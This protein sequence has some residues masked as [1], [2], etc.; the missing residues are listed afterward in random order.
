MTA[1][2]TSTDAQQFDAI[3]GWV[4]SLLDPSLESQVFKGYQNL[5]ATPYDSYIVISRGVEQ[6]LNQLERN[7]DPSGTTGTGTVTNTARFQV[8]WQIDCYG[9]QGPDWAAL[10]S[11]AW[12]T[13]WTADALLGSAVTPLFADGPQQL[14]IVNGEG[15]YETRFMCMIY[16][17]VV[18]EITLPQ[19]FF[20]AVDIVVAQ[21]ADSL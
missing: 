6:P 21:P 16:C 11:G 9:P 15:V 10:V 12:K 3:W 17:E 20:T 13:L 18:Q 5:V 14:N 7:Y 19:T 4:T 2:I 1:T 8:Q